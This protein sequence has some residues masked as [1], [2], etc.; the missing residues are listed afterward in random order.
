MFLIV[1]LKSKYRESN[2]GWGNYIGIHGI[3][4]WKI[5]LP[6]TPQ[7][8]PDFEYMENYI[9]NTENEVTENLKRL[10][11]IMGGGQEKD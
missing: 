2:C 7:G 8:Q 4:N 9:K 11:N 5:P 3:L 6:T 1:I 10:E